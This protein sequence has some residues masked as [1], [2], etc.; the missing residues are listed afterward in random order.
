MAGLRRN[1]I[2]LNSASADGVFVPRYA[3]ARLSTPACICRVAFKHL[4][5][6]L[7]IN[8]QSFRTLRPFLDFCPTHDFIVRGEKGGHQHFLFIVLWVGVANWAG[9]QDI[10]PFI[11]LDGLFCVLVHVQCHAGARPEPSEYSCK[12]Q[13]CRWF[14]G[15]IRGHARHYTWNEA[16]TTVSA[17]WMHVSR[18]FL[19]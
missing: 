14:H 15:C 1:V 3:H 7:R 17:K 6:P 18:C 2:L 4:P 5:Q 11:Y 12:L 16:S 19:L 10:L 9:I 8:I 13:H